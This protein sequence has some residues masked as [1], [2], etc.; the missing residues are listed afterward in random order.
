M[1]KERTSVAKERMAAN[2]LTAVAAATTR[3][4]V[5]IKRIAAAE[6]RTVATAARAAARK[7]DGVNFRWASRANSVSPD[8]GAR[9][10]AVPAARSRQRPLSAG[11]RLRQWDSGPHPPAPR[12]RPMSAGL[13]APAATK[14]E[15]PSDSPPAPRDRPMSAGLAAAAAT[16]REPSTDTQPR[17][18]KRVHPTGA[19]F[20]THDQFPVGRLVNKKT[21]LVGVAAPSRPAFAPPL[22]GRR[23]TA[24]GC[25]P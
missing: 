8:N 7:K 10:D 25:C 6:A 11:P 9:N 14:R 17:G 16:K 23:V 1:A 24:A 19:F 18:G 22:R 3:R 13:V 5:M 15:P 12:D 21:V 2:E 20:A 4:E